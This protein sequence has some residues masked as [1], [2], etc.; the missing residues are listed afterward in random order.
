VRFLVPVPDVERGEALT[1]TYNLPRKHIQR[2]HYTLEGPC[3]ARFTVRVR[4]PD[5]E[6][7][8][9]LPT[10]EWEFP[11]S[12]PKKMA[13]I[14]PSQASVGGE[15]AVIVR[16]TGADAP[17]FRFEGEVAVDAQ[18]HVEVLPAARFQL[19]AEDAGV[20][21]LR[22]RFSEPGMYRLSA[23]AGEFS[24]RSNPIRVRNTG[25]DPIYWGEMHWHTEYSWDARN[26]QPTCFG[27]ADA[28]RF[29]RDASLLDFMSVSDHGQHNDHRAFSTRDA[30]KPQVDMPREDWEAYRSETLDFD[31]AE[32]DI[33]AYVG[34]EHRDP[35]GDT[36]VVFRG[37]APYFLDDDGRRRFIADVWRDAAPGEI[38]TFPQLHPRG[39]LDRYHDVSPHER[40]V[41]IRSWHAAFEYYLNP[42]PFPSYTSVEKRHGAPGD[43]VFVQDLLALGRRLGFV[44]NDDHGD[45]PGNAGVTAVYA[46]ERSH[47][48]I[49]DALLERHAYGTTGARMIVDFRLGE[50]FMGDEETV[51]PD[52]PLASSRVLSFTVHGSA[53][54][55]KITIVRNNREIHELDVGALDVEATFEDTDP[56]ADVLEARQVGGVRS[57]YYYLRA[58]QQD[59]ETAWAS[60]IFLLSE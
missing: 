53:P 5:G 21:R 45:L 44:A 6:V 23:T 52:G 43:R 34:Y 28:L 27:A 57:V 24:A 39:R 58:V 9:E 11:T 31:E 7:L 37:K 14:A 47:D 18:P 30:R 1:F 33:I 8:G 26:Y 60:P 16:V 36:N 15:V 54:L 2:A 40:M 12:G 4:S 56:L 55:D 20:R 17:T 42:Q 50:L 19:G 59:G 10:P 48:A 13:V 46:P 29:A 35:R 32:E 25:I 22:V 41:E 3:S 49:L 38:L 51:E